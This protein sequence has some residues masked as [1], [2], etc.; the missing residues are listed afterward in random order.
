MR[1]LPRVLSLLDAT[2]IVV[3]SVIGSAIFLVPSTIAARSESPG[4]IFVAWVVSAILAFFG[5]LCYAEL[6][7]IFPHTGGQYVFIREAFGSLPSFLYGWTL[8]LVIQT[9]SI[10]ALAVAFSIYLSHFVAMTPLQA[11][12]AGVGL[13]V[14]LT[15]VNIKGVRLG[16]GVQNLLTIL[17][18]LGLSVIIVLGL[19]WASGDW[20]HF[21]PFWPK[22]ISLNLITVFGAI[23][24]PIFWAFEGWH[25]LS[26][27]AGEIKEPRRNIPLALTIGVAIITAVYLLANLAYLH[28]LSLNEIAT[29]RRV[30]ADAAVRFLGPIGASLIAFTI[31]SSVIGAT[32][33]T[34]LTGP[35]VFFAMAR[36]G[37]FFKKV[38]TVHSKYQTPAVSL[39]LQGAWAAILTLTGSYEELFTYLI[40]AAWVFYALTVGGI[41]VVRKKIPRSSRPFQVWGYPYT[42]LLFILIAVCFVLNTIFAAPKESGIGAAL[43]LTGIPAYYYWKRK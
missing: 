10:A 8:F 39:M 35:R 4:F 28:V 22:T 6:G 29:S 32:N 30:A 3:G 21:E 23:M 11:K 9:G 33:G 12:L 16:A 42:P 2:T 31:V 13:I 17:K 18:L 34:I 5:A 37:L 38:A 41:F 27:T 25:V 20:G 43:I 19:F 36:D 15:W 40:F 1:D 26:F 24:V 14:L 7:A